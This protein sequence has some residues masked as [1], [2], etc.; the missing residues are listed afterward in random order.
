[1]NDPVSAVRSALEPLGLEASN[2]VQ[3]RS[4]LRFEVVLTGRTIGG[5]DETVA[6]PT[7]V[8]GSGFDFLDATI[9]GSVAR[10]VV[11]AIPALSDATLTSML[12][13]AEIAIEESDWLPSEDLLREIALLRESMS[14]SDGAGDRFQSA[15]RHAMRISRLARK[16]VETSML[17]IEHGEASPLIDPVAWDDAHWAEGHWFGAEAA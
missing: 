4:D 12:R 7:A 11:A 8:G 10:Y 16:A 9:D 15:R 13:T 14:R 1:M 3:S 5:M 2:I 17:V 6:I